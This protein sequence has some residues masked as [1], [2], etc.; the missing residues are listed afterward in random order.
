MTRMARRIVVAVL[1]LVVIG[2][3]AAPAEGASRRATG[4][5]ASAHRAWLGDPGHR[6]HRAPD[7]TVNVDVCSQ[8]VGPGVASCYAR[9]RTDRF[10]DGVR[11]D[12]PDAAP[13]D[14]AS[15]HAGIGN[16]G[17]YD[18]AYL[19]SAYNAP[20]HAGEGQTVA[21]VL[22]YDAPNLESDL[23][24]YRSY[25]GLP[26][27][28]TAN[29]CFRKVDQNGGT[30][31]P[32][33]NASWAAEATL[34]VQMVSA[35][36]PNCHIL[37]VE[38]KTAQFTNL[39][40]AVDTAVSL[41]ADVVSNSY[42]SEEFAGETDYNDSYNH[43]GV[44]IVASSG[45]SGYGVSYPA[46]APKVV[47]VGGT[48]LVQTG[49]GGTRNATETV[50][51]GAGSGCSAYETKPAW[52]TDGGCATR[53]VADVAAVA[54]PSTG[55]WVYNSDDG[56]WEVF[57][58]TSASAPIIGAFYALAGDA[59]ATDD[60]VAYPYAHRTALND[61]T[62]GSNGSCGV[63]YLCAGRAGYDGPTGLGTPNTASAFSSEGVTPPPPPPPN[64]PT[65]DFTLG[66]SKPSGV[67]TPGATA[68]STVKLTPA[69]GFTGS[70]RLSVSVSPAKGLTSR[71]RRAPVA[72][73]SGPFATPLTLLA[74][75]GGT[76]KVTVRAA[77]G[78]QVHSR[79]L[80]VSVNDFTMRVS[81]AKATVVRGKAVR[82]TVTLRALGAFKGSVRLSVKG[83]SARDKVSYPRNPAPAPGSVAVTV[84]TSVN[85]AKGARTVR[86]TGTSGSLKHN[87]SVVLTFS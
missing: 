15:T 11:P 59:L 3:S 19:Q 30:S 9:A 77:R 48:S 45:D 43:A 65:P 36:C 56:G 38:A 76:Y 67:L 21:T 17:A 66:V 42:G 33:F 79:T 80:T 14:A 74:A 83:L 12:P 41:G 55:V 70:V 81:P 4:D 7:G 75:K 10:D 64:G 40:I 22:A 86:F 28:T 31:Y 29:G 20:A 8:S 26:P 2:A 85:D 58:G 16:Q 51:S 53:S 60:V 78:T 72:I 35:I 18:P 44:A 49:N 52:Q 32:P 23:A 24:H 50:W 27:C 46:S 71:L 69:H 84:R 73:G 47:A 62:S 39:A 82:Y 54:D 6:L 13:M 1:I 5:S 57:G 34:D 25:F 63:A 87:V 68:K 61:V 37:V